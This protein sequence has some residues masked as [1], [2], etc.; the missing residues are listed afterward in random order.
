MPEQHFLS[1]SGSHYIEFM[2]SFNSQLPFCS[3]ISHIALR[4]LWFIQK[5]L[6]KCSQRRACKNQAYVQ[7]ILAQGDN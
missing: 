4:D 5:E 1:Q 3:Y 6:V 7:F 2:H